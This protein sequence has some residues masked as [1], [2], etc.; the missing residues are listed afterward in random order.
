MSKTSN[1]PINPTELLKKQLDETNKRIGQGSARRVKISPVGFT[2]PEGEQGKALQVVVVDFTLVHSYFDTP[3]DPD[4]IVPPAC[5]ANSRIFQDLSPVADVPS[6]QSESCS[7]CPLNQFGSGP[8]GKS[9]ACRN[10]RLLA[11]VPV[12]NI[13]TAP[14]WTFSVAPTSITRWD[15]YVR[16]LMRENLTP[17]F[18]QTEITYEVKGTYAK[19]IFSLLGPLDSTE[20]ASVIARLDEARDILDLL[21]DWSNTDEK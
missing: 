12:G 17:M 3:Y 9:K 19:P 8:N 2:D 20:T 5:Y 4:N 16:E 15:S 6:P 1:L 18:A 21:P 14:I 13:E 11:I 7:I 10:S